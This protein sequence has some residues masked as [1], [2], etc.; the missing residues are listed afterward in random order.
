MT[1]RP[2]RRCESV[3]L[4]SIRAVYS[5]VWSLVAEIARKGSPVSSAA[6]VGEKNC[7]AEEN[8]ALDPVA[9]KGS[10]RRGRQSALRGSRSPL[11]HLGLDDRRIEDLVPPHGQFLEA[12]EEKRA[13]LDDRDRRP[14]RR[15]DCVAAWGRRRR[16]RCRRSNCR[17]AKTPTASRATHWSRT[18][19][20]SDLQRIAAVLGAEAV[21]LDVELSDRVDVGNGHSAFVHGGVRV[22]AVEL[23]LRLIGPCAKSLYE[24][25]AP[26]PP[27]LIKRMPGTRFTKTAGLRLASG[28]C[29]IFGPIELPSRPSLS[30]SA[31]T[32]ERT[33]P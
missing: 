5:Q 32:P 24:R 17:S 28:S 23:K 1:Q 9:G 15:T 10:A 8:R 4:W 31:A 18:W 30:Q 3:K 6:A 27:S 11:Q 7:D 21:G 14:R 2:S 19:S 20:P 29:V 26:G 33:P 12:P 22:Q 13:V 25:S 16:R